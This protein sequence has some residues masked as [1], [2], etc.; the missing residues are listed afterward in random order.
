MVEDFASYA[1]TC[2]KAFGNKV[3]HWT[4]F[5]EPWTFV[6]LGYNQGMHAPGKAP[7]IDLK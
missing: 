3:K 1:E 2:F 6:T 5:N 4:T 7:E